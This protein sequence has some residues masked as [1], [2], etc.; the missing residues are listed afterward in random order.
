M[1][2]LTSESMFVYNLDI[3]Y[4]TSFVIYVTLV[5]NKCQYED[6]ERKDIMRRESKIMKHCTLMY[7]LVTI[8]ANIKQQ[9]M[10]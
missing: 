7:T 4:A 9:I 6:T 3:Q 1:F 5:W 8:F 2:L 10:S